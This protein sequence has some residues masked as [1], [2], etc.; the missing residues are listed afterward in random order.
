MQERLPLV[1]LAPYGPSVWEQ[2]RAGIG[3]EADVLVP[4]IGAQDDLLA[5]ARAVMAAAPPRFCVAG[6]CLGGLVALK[7]HDLAP[8]RLMGLALINASAAAD[9]PL[10]ARIRRERIEKLRMKALRSPWPDSAYV[11]Y[12][13]QWFM[14]P[15]SLAVPDVAARVRH[16]LEALPVKTALAHQVA[17][18]NRPD[19]RPSLYDIRVPVTILCGGQD[20]ICRPDQANA[21]AENISSA[22]L[23]ILDA[24]GHLAPVEQPARVTALLSA[25]MHRV[26]AER[27]A[28]RHLILQENGGGQ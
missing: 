3:A 5:M 13:A 28:E 26:A 15:E 22:E 14:A 27:R 7:M 9:T 19:S 21:L 18:L 23:H 6:L 20:R 1:L 16:V 12:A 10:Q 8:D 17:L 24:C 4:D 11:D 25:W 2:M